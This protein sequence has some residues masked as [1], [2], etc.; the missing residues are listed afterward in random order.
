[1]MAGAMAQKLPGHCCR[2]L[3]VDDHA[4]MRDGLSA[5]LGEEP[6]L[7]VIGTAGDGRSAVEKVDANTPDLVLID[8]SMP[9]TDG[10]R[11]ISVIKRKHPEVRAVVLTFHKEDAHIH[12]ALEAGADGYV[13]KD[14]GRGELL[15]AIRNVAAGRKYLSPGICD[16]VMTRYLHTGSPET[17]AET[18]SWEMLTSREREVL[19]L[20]A[21]G[22]TTREI[23]E[24]LS[25]STKTI[26]KHRSRLMR[27]LDLHNVSDVT[28]YAIAN[29]L[30]S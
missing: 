2:I 5:L 17:S 12:A 8:L 7:E 23:A 22:N 11:A 21:E 15:S 1:M 9:G 14:D 27:K 16:R 20:V 29:G 30:L 13:L 3:V 6:D 28:A 25:L 26:E 4:I 18:A 24:Y 19:K 10:A